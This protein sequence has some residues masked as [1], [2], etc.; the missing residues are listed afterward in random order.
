MNDALKNTLIDVQIIAILVAA[1]APV[2]VL[3]AIIECMNVRPGGPKLKM[4]SEDPPTTEE[5][6]KKMAADMQDTTP[7]DNITGL[8]EANDLLKKF[9]EKK[10]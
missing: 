7:T 10:A 3:N 2:P 5:I 4:I 6:M 8:A 9:M 1:S